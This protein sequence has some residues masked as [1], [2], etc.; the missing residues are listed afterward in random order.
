M[1]L[2]MIAVAFPVVLLVAALLLGEFEARLLAP[3]EPVVDDPAA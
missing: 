2:A 3:R 1:P